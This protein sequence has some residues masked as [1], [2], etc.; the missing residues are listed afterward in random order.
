MAK[1]YYN[2]TGHKRLKKR[3]PWNRYKLFFWILALGV[4][5]NLYQTEI[6][7][8]YMWAKVKYGEYTKR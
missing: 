1:L 2:K 8:A 7:L 5:G 6:K 3:P 4:V